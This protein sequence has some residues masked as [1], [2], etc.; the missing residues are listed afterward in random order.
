MSTLTK[1][2]LSEV[3]AI[4]SQRFV[5]I[6]T[7]ASA[8][9]CF[10]IA[11]QNS[12]DEVWLYAHNYDSADVQLTLMLGLTGDLP[13]TINT[14]SYKGVD[15]TIPFK[16]GRALILDGVLFTYG[17]SGYAYSTA[18]GSITLDGFVNRIT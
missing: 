1:H 5:V 9:D 3:D 12:L 8:A 17:V 16:S 7:E 2:L 10:H 4:S 6:A 18:S 11:S 13:S 14:D 15:I